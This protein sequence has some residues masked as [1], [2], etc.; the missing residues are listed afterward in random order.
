VTAK[1]FA[2][3]LATTL[4]ASACTDREQIILSIDTTVG[5]PC[6]I[7]TLR[8]RATGS[9]SS[10]VERDLTN[11]RLPIAITLEDGTSSG[12]FDLEISGLKNG[13]EV[14]RAAGPL[15]FGRG[16]PLAANVVLEAS[17]TPSEPCA[18]PA[19]EP[20]VAPPPPAVRSRCGENVRRYIPG[21]ATETYRDVCTVPGAN[22]GKVLNDGKR[23]A[24]QLPL[25]QETLDNFSF[26]FYGQPIR[27]IWVHEDGYLSFTQNNP[28]PNNDLDPGPF[29]RDL[30]GQGV[31]PPRQSVFPFWDALTLGPD[32][33]CYA[34]EGSPG[35]QKLRVTWKGTCHTQTCSASNSLNFTV[36]LDERT[37]RVSIT[38]GD[39]IG[40]NAERAQGATATVGIVNEATGC[41]VAQCNYETGLCADG[42]TPCGY[43]QTFS[44]IP[45]MPRVS[46][47]QF[48]PV[49]DP[50]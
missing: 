1:P 11:A 17:C 14:L 50:E 13:Q 10:T 35:T 48:E 21:P 43:S 5:V 46:D 47:V 7:D 45:Q 27:Q 41:P 32:G 42:T 39:M 30:I 19:L 22:A 12:S 29:D 24:V 23:G 2:F 33:V 44:R 38:Y 31:P 34:L 3:A 49:V 36:V 20:Y 26:E 15:Q 25:S 37:N 18:L 40:S 8:I 6:V 16:E 28:D 9:K 4:A